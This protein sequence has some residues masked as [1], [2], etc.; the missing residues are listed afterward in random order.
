MKKSQ[1][2]SYQNQL[3]TIINDNP[4]SIESAVAQTALVYNEDDDIYNFFQNLLQYGCISGMVSELVYYCDTHTFYDLHY[5][6]IEEIRRSY[7]QETGMPIH[8]END[9]KNHMAWF[10]Y[11]YVA[12]QIAQKLGVW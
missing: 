12:Y 1:D 4:N 10:T 7:E 3:E 2:T 8:T 11:E 5:A 9:Y 6:Q